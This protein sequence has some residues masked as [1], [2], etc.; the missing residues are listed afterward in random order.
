MADRAV[1]IEAIHDVI[2]TL[3]AGEISLVA[4]E[5][6]GWGAHKCNKVTRGAIQRCVLAG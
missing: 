5:T 1:M 6:V 3:G 2:R 4:G